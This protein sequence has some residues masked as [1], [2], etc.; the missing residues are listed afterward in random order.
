[1][2]VIRKY[3]EQGK[4][5]MVAIEDIQEQRNVQTF[6]VLAQLQGALYVSIHKEFKIECDIISAST[7]K[8]FSQIRGKNRT[9]QKR[10]AQSFVEKTYGMR[11]TQ[12][13]ADAILLYTSSVVLNLLG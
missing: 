3:Q 12:D 7:W 1:M 5:V 4:K 11:V 9:E 10:N 2:N 8:S 6:K 13:E